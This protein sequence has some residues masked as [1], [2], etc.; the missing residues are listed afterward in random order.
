MAR[1]SSSPAALSR[2]D[3]PVLTPPEE[4]EVLPQPTISKRT[5]TKA[6]TRKIS[7]NFLLF[8]PNIN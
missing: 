8:P 1:S 3:P 4:G 7:F 5:T 2:D 6:V